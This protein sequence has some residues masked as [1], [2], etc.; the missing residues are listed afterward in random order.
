MRGGK[1]HKTR[2]ARGK[3]SQWTMR[4]AA[5]RKWPRG[6]RGSGE[7]AERAVHDPPINQRRREK[8]NG[9]RGARSGSA[10]GCRTGRGG[11]EGLREKSRK[12]RGRLT[13]AEAGKGGGEA[14]AEKKAHTERRQRARRRGGREEKDHRRSQ[15]KNSQQSKEEN[16]CVSRVSKEPTPGEARRERHEAQRGE[17]KKKIASY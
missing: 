17:T 11:G 13:D 8:R 6:Q 5:K 7:K 16:T 1:Q 12:R 14:M 15:K 4:K 3:N 10:S 2:E 9:K